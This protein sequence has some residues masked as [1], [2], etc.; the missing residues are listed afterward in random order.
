MTKSFQEAPVAVD[1]MGGDLGPKVV[2]E[3]CVRAAA[4]LGISTIIVGKKEEIE[5]SLDSLGS[6]NNSKIQILHADDV[7]TMED[8]ALVVLRSK[9]NSSIK[10][11]FDLLKNQEACA[12]LSPG[13]TGAVM[14]AGVVTVGTLS[15]IARP[16]I[17]T[18]IPRVSTGPTV[19]VDSG[20]T[21]DSRA[22]QLSQFALMGSLYAEAA[23]GYKNPKVGILS[24]GSEAS[25]GTD[26]TRAAH[27]I[28]S[29]FTELNFIGYVEGKDIGKNTVDVIVCDGFIGNIVLKTIEGT[30]QLV[31]DCIK[32]Y[33]EPSFRGKLGMLI[34][35]PIFKKLMHEKLDPSEYGG[36]PLLG[37]NGVGIICHG[38]SNPKA[39]RNGIKIA[40]QF[41]E[42][43]LTA[44]IEKALKEH[45]MTDGL[46]LVEDG[47]WAKLGER[48]E[49]RSAV[50]EAK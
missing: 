43:D 42:I 7:I 13:N 23:L 44:Q 28:L 18:L 36:A 47:I 22:F 17:A 48:Y 11:A 14:A 10:K 8:S 46:G 9:P 32:H 39:I 49:K 41:A 5:A 33:V 12:V 31:F 38:S 26:I 30:A 4:D 24:N 20:A 35:K 25:K 50:K 3:G 21:N 37:L 29:E 34:A 40:K 6:K 19:L 45:P 1:A 27:Q 2:V 16:A 15:G